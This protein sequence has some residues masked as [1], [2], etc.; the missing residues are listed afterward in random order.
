MH[1]HRDR[2]S[3]APERLGGLGGRQS[4]PSDEFQHLALG[5]KETID[6]RLDRQTR[7]DHLGRIVRRRNGSA[8][9]AKRQRFGARS[10]TPFVREDLPRH[11]EEP[12]DGRIRNHVESSPRDGERLGDNFLTRVRIAATSR[13]GEHRVGVLPEQGLETPKRVRV[14]FLWCSAGSQQALPGG[15][16]CPITQLMSGA[17]QGFQAQYTWGNEPVPLGPSMAEPLPADLFVRSCRFRRPP[18]VLWATIPRRR[19]R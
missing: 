18:F 10:R 1:P 4:L 14:R 3:G 17:A 11:S 19:K 13:V 2:G 9:D 15:L 5:R 16:T 8:H 6:R 7:V 12:R